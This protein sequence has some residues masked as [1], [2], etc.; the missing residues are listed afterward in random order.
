[1][2]KMITYFGQKAKVAC[3]EK[4]N[5]AWGRNSRPQEM[6]SEDE[7]DW[8]WLSDEELGEAPE[9]PG[10]Y[11]G[12]HGKD[13]HSGN[14]WCIRECERCVMSMPGESDKPLKLRDLSKRFYNY[15]KHDKE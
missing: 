4:C 12:G 8:V 1:M 13:P 2:E 11:E 5:K 10:T 3:D 7:D 6:M 9:D 14:K 15:T